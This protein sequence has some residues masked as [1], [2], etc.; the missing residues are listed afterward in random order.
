MTL[1]LQVYT[2]KKPDFEG[3]L[4]QDVGLEFTRNFQRWKMYRWNVKGGH[5]N[6]VYNPE[7]SIYST[8]SQYFGCPT[9]D[10]EQ[11]LVSLAKKGIVIP[12]D[13]RDRVESENGVVVADERMFEILQEHPELP[14]IL[15]LEEPLWSV[16]KQIKG[17]SCY[18]TDP[19]VKIYASEE[20]IQ[21]MINLSHFL[22]ERYNGVIYCLDTMQVGVPDASSLH[23]LGQE[24]AGAIFGSFEGEFNWRFIKPKE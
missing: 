13:F 8:D 4:E 14:D 15:P 7:P 19:E 17:K 23:N 3:F 22:A 16:L 2:E 18:T 20:V 6:I 24:T 5:V 12:S 10:S 11:E 21:S 1:D 9:E